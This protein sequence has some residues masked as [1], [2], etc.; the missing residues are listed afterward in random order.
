MDNKSQAKTVNL[1]NTTQIGSNN[2]VYD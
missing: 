2:I 1:G